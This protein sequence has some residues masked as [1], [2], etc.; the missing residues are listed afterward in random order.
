MDVAVNRLGNANIYVGGIGLLG[1]AEEI[2]VPRP[3][4][5]L[6]E[7]KGLGMAGMAEFW[8]GVDKLEA[9][10]KW[11]SVYPEVEALIGDPFTNQ[12]FQVRGNLETYTSVGRTVQQPVIYLMTAA[13][14]D[15]G[16]LNFKAHENVESTS[17]LT[18]YHCEQYIGGRQQ[19]LYDVLA[20]IYVV[21]GIDQ[22]AIF[23]A[24]LGG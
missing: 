22:L 18:V 15:A 4:H 23:R 11:A 19:F 10:I 2:T 9:K 14:K 7:H 5:K 24:N 12:L 1:R 16:E 20:N 17:M 6:S 13:F 21:N 3:K 8:S